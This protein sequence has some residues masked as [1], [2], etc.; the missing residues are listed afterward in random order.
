M[1]PLGRLD[2]AGQVALRGLAARRLTEQLRLR[3][4]ARQRGRG[5]EMRQAANGSRAPSRFPLRRSRAP[6]GSSRRQ[7]TSGSI[8]SS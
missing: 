4:R 7:N 1:R 6:V 5:E 8:A 2:L 3:R